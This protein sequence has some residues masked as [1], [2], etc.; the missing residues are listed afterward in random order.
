VI[1]DFKKGYP[2]LEVV[3]R[4]NATKILEEMMLKGKLEI[5]LTSVKPRSAE[6]VVE[7][8]VA[9]RLVACAAKGYLATRKTQLNLSD[10]EKVPLIIRGDGTTRGTTETL[11]RNLEKQGYKLT[12]FMRC[13][14]PDA[15]KSAVRQRLGVGILYEL[16]VKDTIADGSFKQL[17][18]SGLNM[19]GSTYIFYH[20]QRPLSSNGE[21]FLKTCC[22][23]GVTT[24]KPIKTK[25]ERK[26]AVLRE[27][28]HRACDL[29]SHAH[30]VAPFSRTFILWL[31]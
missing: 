17:Q 7:P 25:E 2:N 11:L 16:T 27:F 12:I 22:E 20:K 31:A 15:I 3:L 23:I 5:A 26:E 30:S 4:C 24:S 14:S 13:E 10:L 6:I 19:E 29:A 21:A 8:C 9:M 28:S 18:I 1:A